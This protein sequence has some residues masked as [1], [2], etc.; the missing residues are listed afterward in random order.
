MDQGSPFDQGSPLKLPSPILPSNKDSD[1]EG[2]SDIPTGLQR[3]YAASPKLYTPKI[4][5][6]GAHGKKIG[7]VHPHMSRYVDTC[8]IMHASFYQT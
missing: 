6:P 1:D 7:Y 5:A 8:I 2:R 4:L 3:D